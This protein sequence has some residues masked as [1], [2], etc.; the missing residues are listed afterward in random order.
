MVVSL[1]YWVMAWAKFVSC[2]L[3]WS[4]CRVV[5]ML[6]RVA[7]VFVN[8]AC[9]PPRS[10]CTWFRLS[11]MVCSRVAATWMAA[12]SLAVRAACRSE[13][14]WKMSVAEPFVPPP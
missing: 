13:V 11:W 9:R 6:V 5:F 8:P 3:L 12:V 1:E 4:P 7:W 2:W 14:T 10:A